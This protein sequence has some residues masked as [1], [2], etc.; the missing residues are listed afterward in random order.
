MSSP[1]A[2]VFGN[3]RNKI[4]LCDR[5][6]TAVI[7]VTVAAT[8]AAAEPSAAAG[9][10]NPGLSV[11]DLIAL[12]RV[13]SNH[14][15]GF[16]GDDH[17]VSPNG[18]NV[19][20]VLQKG[21]LARNSREFSLLVFRDVGLRQD[22]QAD[23]VAKFIT[24]TN[25]PGITQVAWLSNEVL[26]FIGESEDG[27]PQVYTLDWHSKELVRRT[28]AAHGVT[29][30]KAINGGATLIYASEDIVSDP[31]SFV[32]LRAHGFTVPSDVQL[33]DLIAGRWDRIARGDA[34][35]LTLHVVRLGEEASVAL[36]DTKTFGRS[37][38]NEPFA[39]HNL[40]LSPSGEIAL[41][42]YRPTVIP[43]GWAEYEDA[44]LRK[45]L[46]DGS[47]YTWWIVLDLRTG[48]AWP[49]T[50]GP[51]VMPMNSVPAWTAD[52]AAAILVDDFLPLTGAD[53]VQRSLRVRGR[54]TAEVNV[55]TGTATILPSTTSH[56]VKSFIEVREGLT[57]PWKLV[58]PDRG[59][60]RGKVIYDPNRAV[61]ATH[62]LAR[63]TLL[64][65]RARSG[66]QLTAGLYWPLDYRKGERYPLL[67]QTHGFRS[68]QFSPE[69]HATTG[70]AAQPLAA[71]GV[72]V[73]QAF[74][75]TKECDSSQ[76]NLLTEGQKVQEGLEGLI[77]RLDA[78]GLIDRNRVALQGYSRSCFHELYF[79]THSDYSIAAMSCTD[80]IDGSYLQYLILVPFM[81]DLA[82]TFDALNGGP[83]FGPTLKTWMGRAPGFLLDR[84]HAPVQ[85]TAL[86][87]GISLLEEWE[88]FAGLIAQG[89]A[90]ELK[91]IPDAAHTIV[92]PWERFTSQQ[93]AVDWFRFWLQ[94][95]ERSVPIVEAEETVKS[96]NDQYAR[97]HQLREKRQASELQH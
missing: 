25:R 56:P 14:A 16:G 8:L 26:T 32:A 1:R 23:T 34:P 2:F 7:I 84:I 20:V 88:P 47:V 72:M 85:L 5:E 89:K 42:R 67:I 41:L 22:P 30:F 92:R 28:H 49:L 64:E 62:R 35:S 52:G 54:L 38:L 33:N 48:A 76:R 15:G 61:W 79:M 45:H 97:W 6:L 17:I 31:S 59:N 11:A 82:T 75:C 18:A 53:V 91:F 46:A 51:S 93:G 29:A 96:L 60:N 65:W 4:S 36:P 87:D 69:G 81:P 90:A 9:I 94:G 83:P 3:W 71:N 80:G 21:D 74:Q 86:A 57:D 66:A 44:D 40:S 43:T 37:M 63:V 10:P 12:T 50:G 27:I 39:E 19:A 68:D 73:V 55:R 70:Y 95:Y 58:A 77:D 78:L 13:G 24:R